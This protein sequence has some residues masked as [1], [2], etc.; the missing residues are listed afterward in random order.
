MM[1]VKNIFQEVTK[2]LVCALMLTPLLTS[3]SQDVEELTGNNVQEPIRFNLFDANNENG[4]RAAT[5]G[6]T[7]ITTCPP[8]TA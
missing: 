1:N 5:D 3:C 8:F 6:Q 7:M 2:M 4:T